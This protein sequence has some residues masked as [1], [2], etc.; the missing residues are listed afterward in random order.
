[1]FNPC[2]SECFRLPDSVLIFP[3][4]H[5]RQFNMVATKP[6]ANHL[7]AGGQEPDSSCAWTWDTCWRLF[8]P[9]RLGLCLGWDS[10]HLPPPLENT[11]K[12]HWTGEVYTY[13][14]PE[15]ICVSTVKDR[16]Q[17]RFQCD[18]LI[19]FHFIVFD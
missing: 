1:M 18:H 4:G 17:R 5:H 9:D 14:V 11:I 10:L 7:E 3:E 13:L 12:A 15:T 6:S 8:C 2:Q 16:R 19:C